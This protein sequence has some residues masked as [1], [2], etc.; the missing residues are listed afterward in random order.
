MCAKQMW[1]IKVL[2]IK[3]NYWVESELYPLFTNWDPIEKKFLAGI[4]NYW[5]VSTVV[6]EK[7]LH[8]YL[9]SKLSPGIPL[10]PHGESENNGKTSV[11]DCN[12]TD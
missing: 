12:E 6:E 5:M 2:N 9:L 10:S 7:S 4:S 11:G 1:P 8:L 3:A